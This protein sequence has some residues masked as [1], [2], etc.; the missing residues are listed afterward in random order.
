MADQDTSPRDIIF[1]L[2]GVLSTK[3]TFAALVVRRFT[4]NPASLIRGASRIVAWLRS[5][6][7]VAL[8]AAAARRVTQAALRQ[9][10]EDEYGQLAT[11]LGSKLGSDSSWVRRDVVD[12]LNM[13]R[14]SGHRIIVAT[15]TERR[16]AQ[17]FLQTIGASPDLLIA[18]EL[19]GGTEG[20]EI[21][22][23]LRG[24]A[25][26]DALV[27]AGVDVTASRFYTDSYDD[28]PTARVAAELVLVHPTE[29]N[30]SRFAAS[31]L[32]YDLL[33]TACTHRR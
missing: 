9:I 3:D 1:D 30:L 19:R 10:G 16:L 17:A 27:E 20:L 24:S 14:E 23:H 31:G 21:Q 12:E 13:C 6:G 29:R 11:G 18:S 15:A 5:R 8:N 25:K 32:D 26:L 7:D 2:D 28:Y 33:S 22:R 4:R